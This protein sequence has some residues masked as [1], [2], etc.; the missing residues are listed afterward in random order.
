MD[1]LV[2]IFAVFAMLFVGALMFLTA[3]LMWRAVFG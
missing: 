3:A 1:S 2:R